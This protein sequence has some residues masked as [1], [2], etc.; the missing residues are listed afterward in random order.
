MIDGPNELLD[1]APQLSAIDE[2]T[3]RDVARLSAAVEFEGR[4]DAT[5]MMDAARAVLNK[6]ASIYEAYYKTE[7]HLPGGNEDGRRRGIRISD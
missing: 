5:R 1:L 4:V 7:G 3:A 2:A 6:G